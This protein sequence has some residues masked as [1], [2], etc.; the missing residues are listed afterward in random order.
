MQTSTTNNP[1]E[2]ARTFLLPDPPPPPVEEDY[3]ID[4]LFE[5]AGFRILVEI[6]P[7][8]DT[9]RRWKKWK[10]SG[11]HVP[12]EAREREWQAQVSARV[13]KMGPLC[14]RDRKR[15]GFW[16]RPWCKVG[17]QIMMRPYSGTR[18]MMRDHLYALINDDTVESVI[19]DVSEIER[20]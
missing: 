1:A 10:E 18:F 15:F 2:F 7:P 11:L 6:L 5:P 20:A 16:R 13:L 14:F 4:H 9:I 3:R 17:D 12:P 19:G 8:E